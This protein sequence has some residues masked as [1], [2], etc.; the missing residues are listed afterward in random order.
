M[1]HT[2]ISWASPDLFGLLVGNTA[3]GGT[4]TSRLVDEIREKR[5][6]SYGVSSSISAGRDTGTLIMRFFP[7]NRDVARAVELAA[8]LF[9]ECSKDGLTPSE[10]DAAV[11]NVVRQ[12]PFRVETVKKRAD[13]AVAD[14]V[15]ARPSGII[16]M[17]VKLVSSQ[18]TESVNGALSRAFRPEDLATV[19]VGTSGA[20]LDELAAVFGRNSIDVMDYRQE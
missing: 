11:K 13:E 5:G 7:E 8:R 17:L 20:L 18:T 19:I 16:S 2:S 15:F 4:F 12:Y 1:G 3:F 6:W 10:V 14:L 9:G